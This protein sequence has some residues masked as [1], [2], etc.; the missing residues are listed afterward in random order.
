MKP[1]RW[2]KIQR[3]FHGAADLPEN[4]RAAFIQTESGGDAALESEVFSLL[5]ADAQQALIDRTLAEVA[6]GVLETSPRERSV[7]EH[8]FG[9]W[10]IT[11]ILGEGGMGVVYLAERPDLGSKAAIKILRD[12]WLSPLRRERFAAEQR[13]LAQLSHPSIAALHDAGTLPEGTPWFVMEYVEGVPITVHCREHN[14]SIEERLRLFREVCEAVQHA[15]SHLVIHRDLKPS[16][17]LVR[18]DGSVKLLDFGISKQLDSVD[19]VAEQT[20]T[21][22]RLMTPAYAAPE[23]IRG[24]AVG[25]HSDVYSLG[26]ILYEL[27]VGRLPF[28]ISARSATEA[29]KILLEREPER[30]SAAARRMELVSQPMPKASSIGKSAWSDLDVVCLTAMHKDPQRRYRTV[31]ALIRDVDHFLRN[32]PLEARPDSARY[33]LRKFVSRNG[34]AV[35]A[36]AAAVTGIVLLTGFYT[37]RMATARN[38]ALAEASRAERLQ[39]FTLDLLQGGDEEVGPSDSIR[40]VTLVDRGVQ[41]ARTLTREPATQ[42]AVYET[43]GSIYMKLGKYP[44]ADSLLKTSLDER[45][46]LPGPNNAD[47]AQSL[48]ALGELREAQ[49]EYDSAESLIT[50]GL[51]MA[52][53]NLP[54]GHPAIA[55]A[56]VSLG[57]TLEEKGDYDRAIAVLDTAVILQTTNGESSPE[58][59]ETMSALA[60]T[61]FYAGHFAI[62]DSLNR[63]ALAMDRRIY[64]PLHPHVADDLMNLGAIQQEFQNYPAAE[65]FY[66]QAL[67]I[68]RGWYG[69]NHPETAS[70]LT[71]LGR[72]LVSE[73]RY[74]D[75]AAILRQAVSI[76]EKVY[77]PVHPRVASAINELGRVAQQQGNL[78]E[79]E[80]DFRRMMLIYQT[81][82]H[83]KHYL[84]GVAE[85]NLAGVYKDRKQYDRAEKLFRDAIRRYTQELSPDHQLLGIARVRLGET[86]LAE[87]KNDEAT[88]NFL[89]AN[90]IL[91]KQSS[92]PP[93]WVERARKGLAAAR[94]QKLV[95]FK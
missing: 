5:E 39:K 45:R 65:A 69:D 6:N 94:P 7:P 92:P 57:Q 76:Q 55:K 24:E 9:A 33:R 79:A 10:R 60:N 19:G 82:Y 88:Q 83:D 93:A 64:G 23:Q 70:N 15:H 21:A 46:S 80:A 61:H 27:I 40:V 18:E 68:T 54:R 72:A 50:R 43:L 30:P 41:E 49:A 36:T 32:E 56:L 58:L 42:A 4:E 11:S 17:I 28:D 47:V 85:S 20:R 62:S 75:A 44:R 31:D 26:V 66:R 12:A 38:T 8:E 35:G 37:V 16:N 77:G 95:A 67:V 29:E 74:D 81:V 63:K 53:E 51:G 3:L 90:A 73:K 87:K 14:C 71:L 1:E 25:L 22:V 89:A 34:R 2:E 52:R 78:D 91:A 59:S 13:T 84:I 48:V 86:L